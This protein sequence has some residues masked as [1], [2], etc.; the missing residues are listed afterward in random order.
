MHDQRKMAVHEIFGNHLGFRGILR[1]F[2]EI[3]SALIRVISGPRRP[4]ASR[5]CKNCCSVA[6]QFG[7]TIETVGN[8]F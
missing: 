2:A 3:S 1:D 7:R 4:L 6:W 5:F 8:A